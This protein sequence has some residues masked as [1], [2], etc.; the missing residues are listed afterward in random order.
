MTH[1]AALQ[2][3]RSIMKEALSKIAYFGGTDKNSSAIA[4]AALLAQHEAYTSGVLR[5]TD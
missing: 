1:E 4:H 5:A 2:A 3:S